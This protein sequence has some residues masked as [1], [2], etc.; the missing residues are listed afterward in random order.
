MMTYFILS[1]CFSVHACQLVDPASPSLS[2]R[3]FRG[4]E[5]F[6]RWAIEEG[7]GRTLSRSLY[8]PSTVHGSFVYS[9][10]VKTCRNPDSRLLPLRKQAPQHHRPGT[11]GPC[12]CFAVRLAEE[13][14]LRQGVVFQVLCPGIPPSISNESASSAY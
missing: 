9:A 3:P 5:L 14:L 10:P 12:R 6:K 11:D 8:L 13:V 2:R 1:V 7:R 4:C